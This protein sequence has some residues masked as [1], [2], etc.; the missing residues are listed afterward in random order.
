MV[1][2]TEPRLIGSPTPRVATPALRGRSR[3][4]VIIR[5]ARDTLG[6]K[7]LP[8]Q[9]YVFEEACRVYQGRWSAR[10]A[11]TVVAR[12]Q[13]KTLMTAVRVLA[14]MC[15][16][17][18]RLVVGAAQNRDIALEAWR[19]TL[20]LAENAGLG[21]RGVRRTNGQEEFWIGDARYR[22]VASNR[23]GGRGLS[24]DLVVLDEVREFRDWDGYAALDKTRRAKRGSQV[25]AIST[26]G[27][28]G[29]VVLNALCEQGRRAAAGPAADGS[30]A[31][32]EWS[33]A[34]W[35]ERPDRD[36][37][38]EANPSLG[39]LIDVDTL[40]HE[41]ATDPA[42][43]FETE[44]L[45]RRVVSLRPWLPEGAWEG[46]GER[47]VSVPDSA[48]GS[49]LF[50]V[51]VG[52]EL[53]H[54]SVVV[55][56]RRPDGRVFAEAVAGFDGAG[57]TV[58][59][60]TRLRELVAVWRPPLLVCV[61]RSAG[62]AVCRRVVEGVPGTELASVGVTEAGRSVQLTFEAVLSKRLVH[63][64]DPLL[65]A[66]L[67][68]LESGPGGIGGIRRR[69]PGVDVDAGVALVLAVGAAEVWRRS[70]PEDFWVF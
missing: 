29:S 34:P 13:G 5:F 68:G 53:R 19:Q 32:F 57:L 63:P 42:E 9:Q 2:A 48:V 16:F 14:G 3:G 45:C 1:T 33:A 54:G 69:S 65:G 61:A 37:W 17:K 59:L 40:V 70:G 62:E 46:C 38:R 36:G 43:V 50:G 56:W 18:E 66:H 60:E 67:A 55:G 24:A 64:P 7:L 47:L 21:P 8:W 51:D 27:D 22:I 30:L 10:T 44:V 26:E 23:Q 6:V 12:Q 4:P 28:E 15:L 35:R 31:Y 39:R 25:W 52:P 11:L 41:L 20:E 58:Q 49:V